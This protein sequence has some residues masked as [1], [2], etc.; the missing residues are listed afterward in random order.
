MVLTVDPSLIGTLTLLAPDGNTVAIG[1]RRPARADG[2]PPDCARRTAGTYSLV[3]GGDSGT[4]GNY[5]LQAILNAA[6]IQSTD[7]INTI[8]TAYDLSSA[9]SGLGTSPYADRAGVVAIAAW[10]RGTRHRTQRFRLRC[11]LRSP[12][13][14]SISPARGRRPCTGTDDSTITLTTGALGGVQFNFYGKPTT[15]STSAPTG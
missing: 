5:T 8:G 10:R 11:H 15:A 9:F 2:R 4:T 7:T 6:Y 1:H 3:V 12:R 14:S 13:P